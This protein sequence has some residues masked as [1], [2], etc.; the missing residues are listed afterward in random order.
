MPGVNYDSVPEFL[1]ALRRLAETGLEVRAW[2]NKGVMMQGFETDETRITILTSTLR[3]HYR[4]QSH[5]P[6]AA[7]LQRYK[8][9]IKRILHLSTPEP[10]EV[11]RRIEERA[12]PTNLAK[13]YGEIVKVTQKQI[14]I[15]HDPACCVSGLVSAVEI[16]IAKRCWRQIIIRRSAW[17]RLM[18]DD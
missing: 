10:F 8:D 15:R 2:G 7:G 16:P 9:E 3:A 5:E 17:E 1:D 11:G 14:F 13:H 18:D 4:M 12:S 6:Y